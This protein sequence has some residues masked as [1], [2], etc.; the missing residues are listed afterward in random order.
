MDDPAYTNRT[1]SPFI[2][3]AVELGPYNLTIGV[4][5]GAVTKAHQEAQ[6]QEQCTAYNIQHA[7]KTVTK[8]QLE[9]ATPKWLLKE[10]EDQIT[11]LKNVTIIDI[12]DHCFD[13]KGKI[14]N[15]LII[16]YQ[17]NFCQPISVSEEIKAYIDKQEE[18]QRFFDDAG[19]PIMDTQMVSQGQVHV[20]ETGLFEKKYI[21][22]IKCLLAQKT[23]W[24]WKMFWMEKFGDYELLRQLT[25]K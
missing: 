24:Q 17:Q 8:N 22:W 9:Q 16:Q 13:R 10:I 19:Q 4:N 3:I 23:W 14:D 25:A 7:C 21:E 5:T 20:V 1:R 6:H 18:C 15:N 12:F 11:G 2:E